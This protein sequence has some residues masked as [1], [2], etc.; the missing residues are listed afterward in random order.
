MEKLLGGIRVL[1]MGRYIACPYCGMLLGAMG[2]E[3][4]RLERP[5][6]E[7]E[8]VLP[9]KFDPWDYFSVFYGVNKKGITLNMMHEKGREIFKELVRRCDVVLENFSVDAAKALGLEYE[10][11]KE[12]NPQI[13]LVSITG[14]GQYGP[15]ARRVSFDPIAQAMSG[16]IAA[17]W[18]HCRSCLPYLSAEPVTEEAFCI[19]RKKLKLRFFR[20]IYRRVVQ[21]Y[22]Q[23]YP[24]RYR[25][26]G[27][28]LLGIDGIDD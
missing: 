23:K 8:V 20:T 19:A 13:I 22:E 26:K 25:W 27:L 18:S 6:G 9:F 11:L 4:I 17:F 10:V 3:V 12:V 16:A 7:Q 21:R 14:F 2:A 15:Y 24:N 28:R 5:G 1:D